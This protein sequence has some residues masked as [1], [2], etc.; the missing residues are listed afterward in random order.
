[1]RNANSRVL[2]GRALAGDL[3]LQLARPVRVEND[4]NCFAMSEATDGAGAGRGCVFGVILGTGVGGG[5]VIDGQVRTGAN[6]IAGEWGH[7]RLPGAEPDQQWAL[8][9]EQPGPAC[10]CGRHGCLETWLSGPGFAGDARRLA[11]ASGAQ[12]MGDAFGVIDAMRA[13]V[14]W[15]VSAFDRYVDRLAR[16]LAAVINMVDPDVIVLGGGLSNIDELYE[17]VPQRWQRYA[18][19]DGVQTPLL[20][21]HH[22]DSS[23]VRGA[24]CLWPATH[25][26]MPLD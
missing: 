15:A 25:G 26:T 14:P 16:G 11:L 10:Y 9:S 7:N 8:D 20:R 2:N 18:F 13:A 6:A 5:L 3:A 17:Q 21:N 22:G 24:A 4:A 19:S 12:P 23:G 1:V